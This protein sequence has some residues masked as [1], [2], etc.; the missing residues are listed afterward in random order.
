MIDNQYCDSSVRPSLTPNTSWLFGVSMPGEWTQVFMTWLGF[1]CFMG[2][3]I[4]LIY[5]FIY[6]FIFAMNWLRT[7]CKANTP[8]FT[9][10]FTLLFLFENK[11]SRLTMY[12]LYNLGRPWLESLLQQPPATE[13]AGTLLAVTGIAGMYQLTQ[14]SSNMSEG[15]QWSRR[16]QRISF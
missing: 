10:S 6:L 5:L 7:S 9:Y 13:I 8:P 15:H 14:R 3:K 12:S 4:I 2:L 16:N 11:S 1:P